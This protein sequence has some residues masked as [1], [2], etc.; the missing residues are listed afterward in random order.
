MTHMREEWT[1]VFID[2]VERQGFFDGAVLFVDA[3]ELPRRRCRAITMPSTAWKHTGKGSVR[4]NGVTI[5][6][7]P[8]PPKPVPVTP[9]PAPK[10]KSLLSK[11]WDVFKEHYK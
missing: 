3:D 9:P 10:P 4:T 2:G 5:S 11:L 7:V 1:T 8:P 6:R